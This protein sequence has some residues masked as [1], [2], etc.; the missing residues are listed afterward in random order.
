[1]LLPRD[2]SQTQQSISNT[3]YHIAHLL[4]PTY[5]SINVI[6][7]NQSEYRTPIKDILILRRPSFNKPNSITTQSQRI[8]GIK[9]LPLCILQ[10]S[11]SP[12]FHGAAR[13]L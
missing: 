7:A 6:E 1:M 2:I 11:L 5:P 8:P 12:T 10:I 9:N 3:N 4:L 13:N